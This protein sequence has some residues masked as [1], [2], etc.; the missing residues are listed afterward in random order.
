M[1]L[2][3]E[4]ATLAETAL[5]ERCLIGLGGSGTQGYMRRPKDCELSTRSVAW[6]DVGDMTAQGHRA[7]G[8]QPGG[9]QRGAGG[10][11]RAG[12][13]AAGGQRQTRAVGHRAVIQAPALRARRRH[14]RA[15]CPAFSYTLPR[16]LLGCASDTQLFKPA[17]CAE[18][19]PSQECP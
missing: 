1:D 13:G 2:A 6:S 14:Q 16:F 15:P 19:N 4:A 18:D 11:G 9:E 17:R 10:R 12:G 7:R 8:G 5:L 3:P